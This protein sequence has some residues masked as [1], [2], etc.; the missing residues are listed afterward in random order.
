MIKIN[1]C[2]LLDFTTSLL[3]I[4][5]MVH[6]KSVLLTCEML[7]CDDSVDYIIFFCDLFLPYYVIY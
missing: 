7:V 3:V 1:R 5:Q 2:L 6:Q 4:A